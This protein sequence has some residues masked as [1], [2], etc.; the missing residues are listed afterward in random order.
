[1]DLIVYWLVWILIIWSIGIYG[2]WLSKIIKLLLGNYIVATLLFS[3][4]KIIDI[5][6]QNVNTVG[7][8]TTLAAKN[9]AL[10]DILSLG[11]YPLLIIYPLLL[12]LVYKISK[13]SIVYA[14]WFL[15]QKA[16]KFIYAPLTMLSI[17]FTVWLLLSKM[18]I[19]NQ[20]TID[21]LLNNT[22]YLSFILQNIWIWIF[23]HSSIVLL[24]TSRINIVWFKE[25]DPLSENILS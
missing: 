25:K 9:T 6:I 10:S 1:M 23:I 7:V 2:V 20:E 4:S 15:V 14:K 12:F 5:I 13:I 8:E 11:K 22:W 18:G 3:L 17:L 16:I 24:I 21:S 19:L